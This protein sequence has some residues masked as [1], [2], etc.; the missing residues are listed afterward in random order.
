[1]SADIQH[2]SFNLNDDKRIMLKRGQSDLSV[3]A[4]PMR[5]S[6]RDQPDHRP[7]IRRLR[8][9]PTGPNGQYQNLS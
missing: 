2:I 8:A 5:L 9:G 3:V 4:A 7:T 1:M 6:L